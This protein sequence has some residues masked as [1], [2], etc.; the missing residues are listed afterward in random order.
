MIRAAGAAAL[1]LSLAL[2]LLPVPN[3]WLTLADYAGIASLV[4]LGL[5]VLTGFG[6][7]TSFGQAT[8]MGFG[9][10]ATALLTTQAGWS[11]WAALPAS[12]AAACLG[13]ALVGAVT[14]RLSG[15]YLALATLA[16]AV[17]FFYLF[18][19]LDAV[20]RNDGLTG[21]PPLRVFGAALTSSRAFYPVIWAAVALAMLGTRNLL[22]SRVGRAIRALQGGAAASFGVSLAGTRMLAFVYAAGLAGLAGWLYAHMQRS[23]NPSPFG[24]NAS[25]EYLLM[26]VVGGAATLPGALLG[27]GLVTLVN[28]RLQD[29]LPRLLGTE[30]SYETVVFGILLV[31]LLQ[32]APNGL[33]PL[34]RLRPRVQGRAPAAAAL[35]ARAV[36]PPRHAPARRDRP[37][38]GVRRADCGRRPLAAS[39]QRRDRRADWPERRRQKHHLRPADRG[40][41][42]ERGPCRPCPAPRS[43][44]GAPPLPH[45]AAWHAASSTS[46]SPPPCPCWT[47]S[48]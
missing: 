33:W 22:D 44:G 18:G 34:L 29:W 25:L 4:A 40:R 12:L 35:A 36:P 24:L 32:T 14:L 41:P 31:L 1:A 16:C 8:F 6:G 27:A 5:V 17:S 15:H 2:P 7:M 19:N 43:P 9:A 11:P 45:G 30:G 47:T 26:A 21:I 13:A 23:V 42:A 37:A 20:G 38:Q 10:Y 48:P 46:G 3:T 39:R 28:D